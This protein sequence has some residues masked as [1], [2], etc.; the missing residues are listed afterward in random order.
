MN[1]FDKII[2]YYYKI[3]GENEE[4]N[5][6]KNEQRIKFIEFCNILNEYIDI[7]CLYEKAG[8]LSKLN[9]NLTNKNIGIKV[10]I[11]IDV[12]SVLMDKLNDNNVDID[13]NNIKNNTEIYLSLLDT[14]GD[15]LSTIFNNSDDI[16]Q[17]DIDNIGKIMSSN[18]YK[19]DLYPE[20][21][22]KLEKLFK[23]SDKNFKLIGTD[24]GKIISDTSEKKDAQEEAFAFQ[25][26]IERDSREI[27]DI[28]M[29]DPTT[30]IKVIT[31]KPLPLDV[32]DYITHL[33]KEIKLGEDKYYSPIKN[34][35]RYDITEQVK[36]KLKKNKIKKTIYDEFDNN[37]KLDFEY[38]TIYEETKLIDNDIE[39]FKT[40]INIIYKGIDYY[41][42]IL[43]KSKSEFKWKQNWINRDVYEKFSILN[44]GYLL[45]LTLLML[46]PEYFC[47]WY[48]KTNITPENAF[49]FINIMLNTF[50]IKTYTIVHMQN[51]YLTNQIK[52][53]VKRDT[54][55]FKSL[56][57][58]NL[59]SFKQKYLNNLS[60]IKDSDYDYKYKYIS[61][62]IYNKCLD[63]KTDVN[64]YIFSYKLLLELRK[65]YD[66]FDTKKTETRFKSNNNDDKYSV[67][68]FAEIFYYSELLEKNYVHLSKLN[69]FINGVGKSNKKTIEEDG[70]G[71]DAGEPAVEVVVEAAGEDGGEDGGKEVGDGEDGG[72]DGGKE[73]G[74]GEGAG[75]NL[76]SF[77]EM[78]IFKNNFNNSFS[79]AR[80][81]I[82]FST[83]ID[84]A[85][86]DIMIKFNQVLT[87][88][89]ERNDVAL[90]YDDEKII[91]K[92][93]QNPRYE[94]EISIDKSEIDGQTGILKRKTEKI[95]QFDKIDKRGEA[96]INFYNFIINYYNSPY[97]I[98]FNDNINLNLPYYDPSK[99]VIGVNSKNDTSLDTNFNTSL[100]TN[101]N[102]NKA[103][104]DVKDKPFDKYYI[105]KINKYYGKDVKSENIAQDPECGKIILQKLRNFENVIIIGNG[106]S[107]A[108]KTAAL[109]NLTL[110]KKL[111]PGLLPS[112]A[113]QLV[114]N[115]K[116]PNVQYFTT[117]KVKL[118]NLYWNLSDQLNDI[119]T[120]KKDYYHPYN[121]KF[122][123]ISDITEFEFIYRKNTKDSNYKWYSED[124]TDVFNNSEGTCIFLDKENISL[125][126]VIEKAF[127]IREE[128]P[129]KN[130]PNSS[131]SHIIVCVT[132]EGVNIIDN[133]Q[134]NSKLVICDLAGVEDR[135]TCD[136]LELLTLDRNYSKLSNKYKLPLD[137]KDK[138][139]NMGVMNFDN[140]F[141]DKHALYFK[142]KELWPTELLEK[143]KEIIEIALDAKNFYDLIENGNNPFEAAYQKKRTEFKMSPISDDIK[144]NI[145][146]IIKETLKIDNDLGNAYVFK[147]QTAGSVESLSNVECDNNLNIIKTFM[148][149]YELP[150]EITN[151]YYLRSIEAI[152]NHLKEKIK[153]ITNFDKDFFLQQIPIAN[154]IDVTKNEYLILKELYINPTE[155]SVD[156]FIS[157][158]DKHFVDNLNTEYIE[159]KTKCDK[160]IIKLNESLEKF[161]REETEKNTGINNLLNIQISDNSQKI[162]DIKTN[163]PILEKEIEELKL[164][165]QEVKEEISK[166]PNM[167][168]FETI[169]DTGIIINNQ[170]T[171]NRFFLFDKERNVSKLLYCLLYY[172]YLNENLNILIPEYNKDNISDT[173]TLKNWLEQKL[174]FKDYSNFID[175]KEEPILMMVSQFEYISFYKW[176][177]KNMSS[178]EGANYRKARSKIPTLNTNIKKLE[179]EYRIKYDVEK[180]KLN[181]IQRNL[182]KKNDELGTSKKNI[183]ELN[184][185]IDEF[186][187]KIGVNN[188]EFE[189]TIQ[190]KTDQVT[191]VITESVK[192]IN[193]LK[194]DTTSKLKE[195]FVELQKTIS[196]N[197]TQKKE[198]FAEAGKAVYLSKELPKNKDEIKEL[199][200]QLI[201]LSQLEFNCEIRR[202]EGYMINTSLLN[203]QKFIGTLLFKSAQKRFNRTLIE[204]N[205]LK[206]ND[207]IY[208]YNDFI[209]FYS[210]IIIKIDA[211][212]KL[213]CDSITILNINDIKDKVGE[214]NF[215]IILSKFLTLKDKKWEKQITWNNVDLENIKNLLKYEYFQIKK[216]ILD[217]F[218]LITYSMNIDKNSDYNE[219][220]NLNL[221]LNYVCFI[222]L[223]LI[224]LEG[225]EETNKTKDTFISFDIIFNKLINIYENNNKYK[226][227][228]NEILKYLISTI[229]TGFTDINAVLNIQ[230]EN[231]D[232]NNDTTILDIIKPIFTDNYD[233]EPNFNT[234]K[235]LVNYS[236][237]NTNNSD[238]I[239]FIYSTFINFFKVNNES[240]TLPQVFNCKDY[241]EDSAQNISTSTY[242]KINFTQETN[243]IQNLSKINYAI[244]KIWGLLKNFTQTKIDSYKTKVEDLIETNPDLHPTPILYTSPS[245]DNCITNKYRY[246]NEYDKFY[247]FKNEQNLDLEILFKIMESKEQ[248]GNV[249][250]FDVDMSKSTILLFTVINLTPSYKAPINNPPNPPFININKLKLIYKILNVK[251]KTDLVE[252]EMADLL[253]RDDHNIKE[254]SD[255]ITSYAKKFNDMLLKYPFYKSLQN[256]FLP[257]LQDKKI[258]F[259]KTTNNILKLKNVIDLIESN[260]ATTLIGTVDFD[261]FTK[262]RDPNEVYFICDDKNDILLKQLDK[263]E[264]LQE[265]MNIL[266][267]DVEEGKSQEK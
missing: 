242:I 23:D 186:K 207:D 224:N 183:I 9:E 26:K 111:Y 89:K 145:Y 202:K 91:K 249:K 232:D 259:S 240:E 135:F 123:D 109:I 103:Y 39:S 102:I 21:N 42:I 237:L 138:G 159:V 181:E 243:S 24:E 43:D 119:N 122:N 133:T 19:Q 32:L 16:N 110:D 178:L 33:P 157:D 234:L 4:Y 200:K 70:D 52:D 244:S 246:D 221:L 248:I 74:D 265:Q 92:N 46:N 84:N 90:L 185:L 227:S 166:L 63:I 230:I 153:T 168:I 88:V 213:L 14:L 125:E 131:R 120:V 62:Y 58:Q 143:R 66:N 18:I 146:T 97:R 267:E 214:D 134:V 108:G 93:L 263:I 8:I 187:I 11:I 64:E 216:L 106:Q 141:C 31:D 195:Y 25:R 118:I 251:L 188:A 262:N 261:R 121:I 205:L 7:T 47:Q 228:L 225:G 69:D 192:T 264:D 197:L 1:Y 99:P 48:N 57:I 80:D 49:K 211:F 255:K 22:E 212:L 5:N 258:L 38:T 241:E 239:K 75:E 86:S 172:E 158:S 184:Q 231:Y 105:G 130:N 160:E 219:L 218:Y 2:I 44:K 140:Y 98:G 226:E 45:K 127:G 115:D 167:D 155:F 34:G 29:P 229:Q 223:I 71:E 128:E 260:N 6:N 190:N 107:G 35:E 104:E 235:M 173:S 37:L 254:I 76:S 180:N 257:I 154:N 151:L 129:T 36:L 79:R 182:D 148:E 54:T 206:M 117:I 196:E 174:K 59:I 204:N 137:N 250:G 266:F 210:N 116:I 150:K 124:N 191:I 112:I 245:F 67:E 236:K 15:D 252:K 61:D 193:E 161:K 113:A 222:D 51:D 87:Y 72:E 177:N 220:Y 40:F 41:S 27:K 209:K 162:A 176:L 28:P 56:L 68:Y 81:R 175:I 50:F 256:A 142:S 126:E 217:H 165:K 233:N 94:I 247:N 114:K 164:Q 17:F 253:L 3:I 100:D 152:I 55:I 139:G 201:R 208:R 13:I 60:N 203:M 179:G 147:Y 65:Y 149:G 85:Y 198:N 132:F 163:I 136:F 77:S 82:E 169:N 101:F 189:T 171:N 95:K 78:P 73:V 238:K 144:R 215:K 20:P 194:T 12:F 170:K 30:P 96:Q 53:A 199:T 83:Q 10:Q 156:K